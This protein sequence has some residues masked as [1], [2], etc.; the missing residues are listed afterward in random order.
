MTP[1]APLLTD[2]QL[3]VVQH[4]RGH[5]VVLATPGSGKTHTMIERIVHLVSEE[6]VNPRRILA[7]MFNRAPAEEFAQRLSRRLTGAR[8]KQPLSRTFHQLGHRLVATLVNARLLPDAK[9]DAT[10]RALLPLALRALN[11]T[12]ARSRDDTIDSEH[13]SDFLRFID[14]VK[15][16]VCPPEEVFAASD[17]PPGRTHFSAAFRQFEALRLEAGLRFYADLIWEPLHALRVHPEACGLVS[18]HLDHV[19]VDEYQDVNV[20]QHELVRL[21]AGDRA[22]VMVVG[23]DDQCIYDWRGANPRLITQRFPDDY[24]GATRYT[25]SR[26]FRYGH[27]LALVANHVIMRNRLRNPKLCLASP[28]NPDT[29]VTLHEVVHPTSQGD[30]R[31]HPVVDILGA[32]RDQRSLSEAA[33]LLRLWNMSIPIEL[34]LLQAG[35][36]YHLDN[37]TPVFKLREVNGL[38]GVLRLAGARLAEL[39]PERLRQTLDD[40]LMT[41]HLGV[42]KELLHN[43]AREI[44][45]APALAH[46]HIAGLATKGLRFR[47]VELVR[48]RADLWE[49]LAKGVYAQ[50]PPGQVLTQ[51]ARDTDLLNRVRALASTDEEGEDRVLACEAII[52][53]AQAFHGTTAEFLETMDHLWD[54]QREIVDGPKAVMITTVHRAKGLEWPLVIVP[55]LSDRDFPYRRR[56]GH[57]D[58]ESERRLFYVAVTR[59]R[60]RLALLVPADSRL[61]DALAGGTLPPLPEV[62]ASRFVYETNLELS[63]SVASVLHARAGAQREVR[64]KRLE[65]IESYLKAAAITYRH[66][67]S[68]RLPIARAGDV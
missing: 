54:R 15:A 4:R 48:R 38:L 23:D 34:A 17:L 10:E 9:L 27:E 19:I 58:V 11:E 60:E 43:V 56:R 20:A 28:S 29:R 44:A 3:A 8:T 45:R 39:P 24:P 21:L 46:F 32:W 16:D 33:I 35:I 52:E 64:G 37:R 50:V 59:A 55:G 42:A 5:A 7:L 61:A 26:T 18:N 40:M 25:L 49:D 41:P 30:L 47:Q 67:A 36:P 62:L 51:Y 66:D 31:S 53:Q 13:K 65:A 68:P 14:L 6:G 12:R 1:D 22:F 2:E 57:I 63:R